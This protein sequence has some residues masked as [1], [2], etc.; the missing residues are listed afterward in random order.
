MADRGSSPEITIRDLWEQLN[1]VSED[2]TD[3]KQNVA[4]LET[5]IDNVIDNNKDQELRL[6]TVEGL[7]TLLNDLPDR[8][9]KIEHRIWSIPSGATIIA[10]VAL[11]ITIWNAFHK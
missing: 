5:K 6:R 2:V 9:V 7:Y 1:K 11:G 3:I 8:V 4:A 10:L